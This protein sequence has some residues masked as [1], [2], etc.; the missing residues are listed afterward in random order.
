MKKRINLSKR[1]VR[2]HI[3]LMSLIYLPCLAFAL[4]PIG[5]IGQ[6]LPQQHVF[7]SNETILRVVPT[8]IQILNPYTNEVIDEFGERINSLRHVS[9]V[10][11][12]PTLEHL[13]ILNASADS[14]TT[15]VNIWDV[16]AREQITQWETEGIVRVGAFSPIGALFAISYEDEIHLWNWQTGDFIET[17]MGERRPWKSHHSSRDGG[18]SGTS[19]PRDHASVFS[20]DGRY[21]FVAS[22]RSGVELWNVETR[23]LEGHFEGHT[24]NWVEDVVISPDGTHLATFERGWNK[25][26]VWDTQTQQLLWQEETGIGRIAD[27]VFSPDSQ[28]LY[29]ANQTARLSRSSPD[30]WEGWDDQVSVWDVESEKQIDTFGDDFYELEAITLSPDGKI[31]LL[32]YADAI[33]LWDIQRKQA[34]NVWADFVYGWDDMLSPDGQTFVSVSRY[35]IKTWDVPSQKMRTLISAE[36]NLFR[37][38]AISPGGQK[39]A[40]GRDPWIEVRNLHTG[41]VENRFQY[42]YGYSDIAFSST[43]RWVAARGFKSIFLFDL[44]N[45]EELQRPM[46]EDGPEIDISSLF[47]FSENDE[48]L[49]AY[50]RTNTNNVWQYWIVLWKRDGD[51][52]TFQYAWKVPELT[53]HSRLAFAS[54]ADGSPVLAVPRSRD[55]QIWKLLPEHPQL[56]KTLDAGYPVHF[57]P[58]GRYLFAGRERALQ[59]WDWQAETQLDHPSIPEYFNVSRDGTILLSYANTGQIHV[60]D[61][62][63]LLPSQPVSV[64]P[65][66]KQIVML[67]AVKQNQLL[68]NF[69]NPFNPETWIPFR[70]ANESD[71]TIHIYATTGQLVCRLSLGIIPAGDY[72]SQARAVYWDGRN[73]T[74]EPVSSGVY[75]Y[76]INTGDFSATRKMLIR[77]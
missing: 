37:E 44:E 70:L 71:V 24:G 33:V 76:T 75:L 41:A 52:F 60:W 13:A 59:I 18:T 49:A 51:T 15:T 20:S 26:Y 50:T 42:N 5:T 61:I 53:S 58:D 40:I 2:F 9:H 56:L 32:H 77:K 55:T 28:H 16:E 43:G 47:T 65:K 72:S 62:K 48:Y 31:M 68:Q 12:S 38:F 67:A 1:S 27:A 36:R 10:F 23:R 73:Q 3:T 17:M 14:R 30:P 35:F 6:P 34:L 45:P 11:I 21:L 54:H 8:H 22:N 46:T 69:P 63:A 29:V 64:D 66:S 19:I 39:I 74:G 7:L 57:S 25:V 4:E